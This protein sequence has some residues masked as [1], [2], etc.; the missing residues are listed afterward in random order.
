MERS[1]AAVA[2][3]AAKGM[4]VILVLSLTS[5]S[6]AV[7]VNI[8]THERWRLVQT[9]TVAIACTTGVYAL[10]F[11]RL[12]GRE[13]MRGKISVARIECSNTQRQKHCEEEGGHGKRALAA[14]H[15]SIPFTTSLERRRR[16]SVCLSARAPRT[17]PPPATSAMNSRPLIQSPRRHGRAA[18]RGLRGRAPWPF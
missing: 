8:P 1:S 15:G 10:L 6:G 16:L 3:T 13:G 9:T 5:V 14:S 7:L 12:S 18:S 4:S 17:V 11:S 2:L